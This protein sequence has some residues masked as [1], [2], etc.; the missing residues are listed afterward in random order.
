MHIM[1]KNKI[2]MKE[3][4]INEIRSYQLGI[5][6]EVDS[7]CK[8]NNICYS[9]SGGTL[10]GAVRHNG[11]IPWDDDIDIMMLRED[12][13]R[14]CNEFKSEHCKVYTH[15]NTKEYDY[16]FAKVSDERTFLEEYSN[17]DNILGINIDVF[18][19]DN[20]SNDLVLSKKSYRIVEFYRNLLTLKIVKVT[21]KR[22][23]IKNLI[24]LLSQIILSVISKKKLVRLIDKK[25]KCWNSQK[26]DYVGCIVWGYGLKE[27]TSSIVF[28][29]YTDVDFEGSK[30]KAVKD[31]NA[32]L[33]NLYGDYMKLPPLEKRITHHA[34]KAYVK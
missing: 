13:E 26:T 29:E 34:F 16:T 20:Y 19:I 27:R 28:E 30:F 33:S 15:K 25:A 31:Y 2:H 24:L 9:L 3:L 4:D 21:K 7:F 8:R 32:Y 1:D 10:I 18:P 12:Y 22:S 6:T 11:Y 17:Q 14:F 23:L 5:L